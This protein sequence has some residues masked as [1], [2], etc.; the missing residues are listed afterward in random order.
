MHSVPTPIPLQRSPWFLEQDQLVLAWQALRSTWAVHRAQADAAA[1]ER[2]LRDL[3]P[4]TL[5]DIGAPQGLIGQRR[6]QDERERRVN[7]R[8][9]EMRGG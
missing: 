5:R 4:H 2:E 8:L 1:V 6:W 3:D 7:D 9:L